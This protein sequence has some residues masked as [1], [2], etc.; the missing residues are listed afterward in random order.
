MSN[1]DP[2]QKVLPIFS[3]P[4]FRCQT[5]RTRTP[6][7]A[8]NALV[9]EASFNQTQT[10]QQPRVVA[11][12]LLATFIALAIFSASCG[13]GGATEAAPTTVDPPAVSL[14]PVSLSFGS[15]PL[16]ESSG[17]Q[18]VTLTY[19]GK[20]TLSITNLAVT[21]TNAGD[22]VQNNNCASSVAAGANCTINVTFAPSASGART[23]S[24]NIADNAP[25][26]PQSVSL[27]GTGTATAANLSPTS[28]TFASQAVG[29][30]SAAEAITLTNSG[31]AA[32]TIS[33]IAL[34]GA[35][36]GDFTQNTACGNSVAAGA[37]CAI[38]VTFTP[39]ASG[40][41]TASLSVADNVSG[42][43]Q[44]VS[45]SGTGKSTAAVVSLSATSLAF[46]SLPT[47]TASPA[48][49][50]ILSNSGTAALSI[51]S[52][53]VSGANASSFVQ[54]NT[55]GSSVAAGAN[56]AIS[57]TFAPSAR[58]TATATLNI[59]DNVSGSPQT[60]SLAG[61]GTTTASGQTI[62]VE[63]SDNLQT[64][65]TEYP[66]STTFSLAPG[67]Y[68]LQSVVPQDGRFVCG[69][70]GGNCQR[71]RSAHNL[72]AGWPVLDSRGLRHPACILS[73][74]LPLHH[75]LSACI[76]K[77]CFSTMC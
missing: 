18:S 61:T 23:A 57:V 38:T 54:T 26:S 37:N 60:V 6:S 29:T 49:T 17:A 63:P 75:L 46:G 55:C 51:T 8:G 4:M 35:N 30:T 40:A 70:D 69:A 21:G 19:G 25:G 32:L 3:C 27:S 76:P 33:S 16:E 74:L 72:R 7:Q 10:L 11:A 31:N 52:L 5:R 68:R 12:T 39:S 15:Q 13:G 59:A 43:P 65:V 77:I 73:R 62:T 42:S 66:A 48:Q 41:A 28:L 56:C 1:S 14:S 53:A 44:T 47:G 2:E 50:I 71:R 58:G 36:P 34:T 64:L 22:F 9:M 20:A 67:I 45:L 24:L